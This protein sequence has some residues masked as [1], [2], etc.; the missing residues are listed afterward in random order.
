MTLPSNEH[1]GEGNYASDRHLLLKEIQ[2]LSKEVG[3]LRGDTRYLNDVLVPREE[4]VARRRLNTVY[5]L[6]AVVTAIQ[7]HDEHLDHCGP[8]VVAAKD[9]SWK[10]STENFFCDV[11][12]PLHAHADYLNVSSTASGGES[13]DADLWPTA[14]NVTGMVIYLLLAVLALALVTRYW[15]R[16]G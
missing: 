7:I 16:R 3:K 12:F 8:F 14:G 11:T 6:S 13:E 4:V 15:N 10:G 5:S 1:E 9:P 2:V